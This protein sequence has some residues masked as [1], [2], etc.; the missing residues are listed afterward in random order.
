MNVL[1]GRNDRK[2]WYIIGG[3][4]LVLVVLIIALFL[5]D[6]KKDSKKDNNNPPVGDGVNNWSQNGKFKYQQTVPEPQP[7]AGEDVQIVVPTTTYGGSVDSYKDFSTSAELKIFIGGNTDRPKI[8]RLMP[9]G[10]VFDAEKNGVVVPSK[11]TKG[12]KVRV[13]ALGDVRTG[14]ETAEVVIINDKPDLAYSPVTKV[15]TKVDGVVLYNENTMTKYVLSEKTSVINALSGEKFEKEKVKPGDRVFFYLEEAE[16]QSDKR[17][18]K[19]VVKPEGGK[20]T[21]KNDDEDYKVLKVR[22]VYI[23]PSP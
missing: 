5:G 13:L 15:D 22:K 16:V 10:I 7:G 4:L 18:S 19:K 3:V 2:K 12:Q 20:V 6:D 21:N 11:L 14:T 1:G 23:Y 8:F 17:G 9:T